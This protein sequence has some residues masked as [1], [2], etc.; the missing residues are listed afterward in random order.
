MP[1]VLHLSGLAM[2]CGGEAHPLELRPQLSHDEIRRHHRDPNFAASYQ[3]LQARCCRDSRHIPDEMETPGFQIEGG[4]VCLQG[5]FDAATF[6]IEAQT[7][8]FLARPSELVY[9]FD[10]F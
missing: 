6:G 5:S 2:H 4:I 8:A 3:V 1:M 7:V 9:S 10:M